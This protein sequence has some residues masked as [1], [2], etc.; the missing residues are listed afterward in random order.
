MTGLAQLVKS[1][2]DELIQIQLIQ[3]LVILNKLV[4]LS[5]VQCIN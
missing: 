2:Q 1:V 4:K 3:L 5:S